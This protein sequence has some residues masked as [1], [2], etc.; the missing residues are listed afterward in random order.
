V[1]LKIFVVEWLVFVSVNV[2]RSFIICQIFREAEKN[3]TNE[4]K[5]TTI[6][7]SIRISENNEK[8]NNIKLTENFIFSLLV[9]KGVIIDSRTE[10]TSRV[11]LLLVNNFSLLTSGHLATKDF[12]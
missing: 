6:N 12:L 2:W 1:C 8:G 7:A 4:W 11:S 3:R 10:S 9:L 5:G